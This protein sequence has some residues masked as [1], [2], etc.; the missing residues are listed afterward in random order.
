MSTIDKI[1]MWVMTVAAVVVIVVGGMY[2]YDH[3]R[4][5]FHIAN[6]G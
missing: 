4:A 1:Q 2:L 5:W 3:P 6:I